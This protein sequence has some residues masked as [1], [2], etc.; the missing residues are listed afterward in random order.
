MSR[1]PENGKSPS[2][3][4]PITGDWGDLGVPNLVGMSPIKCYWTL[5][6]SR[7]AAFTVSELLSQIKHRGRSLV[8]YP[9]FHRL[10]LREN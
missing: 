6:K 8:N 3:F 1:N 7:V 10:K 2:E 5:Q 4:Y 9:L